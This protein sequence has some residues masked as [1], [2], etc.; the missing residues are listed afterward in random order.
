MKGNRS[1][2]SKREREGETPPGFAM[3]EP[4]KT[5]DLS[6][7]CTR[8]PMYPPPD[9]DDYFLVDVFG[10]KKRHYMEPYS[11]ELKE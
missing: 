2:S 9:A 4:K 6:E 8:E 11:M 1:L 5:K 10:G 3:E 7:G